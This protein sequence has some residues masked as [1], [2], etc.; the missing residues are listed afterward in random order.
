MAADFSYKL[1]ILLT[2]TLLCTVAGQT[3]TSS[4]RA[5]DTS[6]DPALLDG[7]VPESIDSPSGGTLR[8]IIPNRDAARQIYTPGTAAI[9]TDITYD[10]TQPEKPV[11]TEPSSAAQDDNQA[12]KQAAAATAED[13]TTASPPEPIREESG[14]AQAANEAE[15]PRHG[16]DRFFAGI[17]QG[18]ESLPTVP[19]EERPSAE[20]SAEATP[21]QAVVAAV[22]EQASADQAVPLPEDAEQHIEMPITA[23]AE[24]ETYESPAVKETAQPE[25]PAPQET[26]STQDIQA[27][28]PVEDETEKP[29]KTATEEQEEA[30]SFFHAIAEQIAAAQAE[31]QLPPQEISAQEASPSP[32]VVSEKEPEVEKP[33]EIAGK[34][35]DEDAPKPTMQARAEDT[36][37]AVP[38]VPVTTGTDTKPAPELVAF[39]SPDIVVK[40]EVLSM[41]RQQPELAEDIKARKLAALMPAAGT[42]EVPVIQLPPVPPPILPPKSENGAEPTPVITPEDI[43]PVIAATSPPPPGVPATPAVTL[44]APVPEPNSAVPANPP[45]AAP[46]T[47]AVALPVPVPVPDK[48][49][50]PAV[51]AAVPAPQAEQPTVPK[52]EAPA[53]AVPVAPVVPAPTT[54][55]VQVVQPPAPP[56]V[57]PAP[58]V[59]APP[60]HSS[61]P[62]RILSNRT[63]DILK[64]IPSNL[65]GKP[66]ISHVPLKI[67]RSKQN[68]DPLKGQIE[69]ESVKHESMGIKIEVKT[70]QFNSNYELEKAYTA[71]NGGQ[72]L[73]AMKIYRGVLDNDPDNI[74]A[75]FG[76][77]TLYHRAGQLDAARTLYAKLL[78]VDPNNRDGLNNFLVLLSDEAPEAA[79]AQLE[80]LE[81]RNPQFSPIPAQMAVIYNKLGQVDKATE[82][83]FR[84]I[85][86]AP[87]NLTYRY[88]LAIMLDKQKNY[89]EAAKLYGQLIEAYMRGEVIPGNPQKIQQRLTFISSNRH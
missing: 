40:H 17:F 23:A 87:E 84:A 56:V 7:D 76:L 33:L 18:N 42:E 86:L 22:L 21:P 9:M 24:P 79:L 8:V 58:V 65:E 89:E 20:Q 52:A 30:P 72:S 64:N 32:E 34:P 11:L 60:P 37:S 55:I 26:A 27:S 45:A 74:G 29:A 36:I 5:D 47:P 63:E 53:P 6:N 85:D 14:S 67:D 13:I 19:V 83:M 10:H 41:D 61:E 44:P 68:P 4:A 77:A 88:N 71:L 35:E 31:K 46:A 57:I 16:I 75:L 66:E 70:P 3:N 54:P 1:R 73:E 39:K 12:E 15:A 28:P 49:A 38:V 69:G 25:T 48:A 43:K 82:K 62:P 78:A 80:K 51:I 81:Q 50:S 59:A 2:T